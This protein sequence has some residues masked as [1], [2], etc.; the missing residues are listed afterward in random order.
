MRY[1]IYAPLNTIPKKVRRE[2]LEEAK[3]LLEF[4]K[5]PIG[6][7]VDICASKGYSVICEDGMAVE[8]VRE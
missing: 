1:N 2:A 8:V 4:N 7:I 6:D 5:I 3:F